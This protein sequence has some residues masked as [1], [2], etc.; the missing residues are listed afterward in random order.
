MTICCHER[1]PL[2]GEV[3]GDEMHL[4]DVG[5]LVHEEWRKTGAMRASIELHEFVVMPNHIHG[6][7]EIVGARCTRPS[8]APDGLPDQTGRVQRAPTV[9]DVVRG[10]KSAVTKRVNQ[11]RSLSNSPVWQRNYHEHIIRDEE[12]Y[13][14][15]ADYVQTNPQRWAEDSYYV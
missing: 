3:V 14:K 12:A 5:R 10:Y 6:I 4:N 8:F 15:I 1:R 13:L 9:G 7:I 2:F 11:L